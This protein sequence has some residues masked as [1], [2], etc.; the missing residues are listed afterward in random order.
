MAILRL[1]NSTNWRQVGGRF[2]CPVHDELIVEV[3]YVFKDEG[4][5][6]LKES[7]EQAGSFLPFSITCDIEMTY[8]W[9]GLGLDD[10]AQFT[11][12][13]LLDWDNLSDSEISWIQCMLVET[14]YILPTYKDAQGNKPIGVAA[15]GVNGVMC[16]KIKEYCADYMRKNNITSDKEFLDHIERRVLYGC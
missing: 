10:I 1:C 16:D 11:K 8:R 13:S 12:P 3:P 9:Y 7:M 5:T 2:L 14:E 6:I 15:K 4:A